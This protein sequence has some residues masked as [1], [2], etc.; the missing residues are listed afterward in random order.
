MYMYMFKKMYGN[1][2]GNFIFYEAFILFFIFRLP[3]NQSICQSEMRQRK[4]K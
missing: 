4:F 1:I 3:R 2:Y